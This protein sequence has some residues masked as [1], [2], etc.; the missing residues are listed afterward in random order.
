MP[1]PRFLAPVHCPGLH[2]DSRM[3]DKPL[4]LDPD[5]PTAV[6][7]VQVRANFQLHLMADLR[8]CRVALLSD[9]C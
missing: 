4:A 5:V 2:R 8:L 6:R 1:G 9:S 7:R 3:S